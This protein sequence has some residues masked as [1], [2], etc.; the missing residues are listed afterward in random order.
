MIL[1]LGTSQKCLFEMTPWPDPTI[2]IVV[3]R[4]TPTHDLF[5]TPHWPT[6]DMVGGYTFM[7]KDDLARVAPLW[8]QFSEDVREDPEAW[9][10]SGDQYVEKG[11]KP[12]IS[13][14]Y[15]YSFACAKSNVWHTWD[16][17]VMHYPTY[18]PSGG[19]GEGG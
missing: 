15:G 9:R 12:W 16:E 2:V 11:G 19:K 8:L 17:T 4:M 10:L 5:L 18:T 6:K 1:R 3:S 14:M 13:E 7:H